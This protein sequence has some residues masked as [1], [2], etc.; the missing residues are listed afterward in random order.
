MSASRRS[1]PLLRSLAS[2]AGSLRSAEAS[3]LFVRLL[4]SEQS[5]SVFAYR[6]F[7][8]T[9]S[10]P[11]FFSTKP[12][13]NAEP[14]PEVEAE[15]SAS[16]KATE[17]EQAATEK[18][19]REEELEAQIKDLKD[20]L[21]RSLAEQENTRRIAKR[22]VESA[23]QFAVTSFAK[24]L[25]ETSDNLS[26][27]ME[28]VPEEFRND[29]QNYPELSTLYEGIKMTEDILLKA[30]EKNGLKKFGAAGEKFDPNMHDALFEYPDPTGRF[31]PGSLG[32]VMKVGFTLNGRVIRPAEVGVIKNT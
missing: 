1:L 19:S 2:Q 32:S 12:E 11:R 28:A 25:L 18:L 24:S 6:R 26:R 3:S 31:P 16:E 20:Q 5:P 10:Y 7:G 27:A 21:L 4:G 15:V 22:D 29:K 14:K 13:E 8:A 9:T 30:F 23:R 17:E